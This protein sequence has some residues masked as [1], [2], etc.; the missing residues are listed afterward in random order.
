MP[1][2][3]STRPSQGLPHLCSCL[4]PPDLQQGVHLLGQPAWGLLRGLHVSLSLLCCLFH[5]S[6]HVEVWG[7]KLGPALTQGG[8]LWGSIYTVSKPLR[9][10]PLTPR[11]S[12]EH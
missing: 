6:L 1:H 4:P 5:I 8:L 2:P 10:H 11:Y 12:R 7:R 9:F 3:A